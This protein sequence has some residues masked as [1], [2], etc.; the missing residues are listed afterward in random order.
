[1]FKGW[2]WDTL[3]FAPKHAL[4]ALVIVMALT[5]F[6][7]TVV[8][9]VHAQGRRLRPEKDAEPRK[10]SLYFAWFF[11]LTIIVVLV[12]AWIKRQH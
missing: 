12:K 3:P 8:S 6:G 11:A 10:P 1:M 9:Q 5:I 4:V 7:L 2:I